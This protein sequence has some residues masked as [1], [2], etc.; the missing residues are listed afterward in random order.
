MR[1]MIVKFIVFIVLVQS[2]YCAVLA[3]TQEEPAVST[4]GVENLEQTIDKSKP[5]VEQKNEQKAKK[6]RLNKYIKAKKQIR[7]QNLKKSKKQKELEFLEHRLEV[8]QK[9]LE[10]MDS[11][12]EKGV[13]E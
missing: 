11:S 2:L 6:N 9:K 3:K 8:K 10:S 5:S 4:Q 1:L 7:R 12:V 13:N